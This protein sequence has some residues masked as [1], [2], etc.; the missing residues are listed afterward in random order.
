[1]FY[2]FD[3]EEIRRSGG[4]EA[5]VF[6][7]SPANTLARSWKSRL[8]GKSWAMRLSKDDQITA[9]GAAAGTDRRTALLRSVSPQDHGWDVKDLHSG[10]SQPAGTGEREILKQSF[11]Y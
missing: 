11:V 9:I 10:M 3:M 8:R 5:F 4:S 1:M 2:E 6:I 7:L